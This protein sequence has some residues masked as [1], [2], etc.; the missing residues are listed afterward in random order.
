MLLK[1]PLLCDAASLPSSQPWSIMM[2][3]PPYV[4]TILYW[5]VF[6]DNFLQLFVNNQVK[7]YRW[8]IWEKISFVHVKIYLWIIWRK[9]S[10]VHVKKYLWI[11]WRNII[12]SCCC[13]SFL[14]AIFVSQQILRHMGHAKASCQ[15]FSL[16]IT[17][18][19]LLIMKIMVITMI[20]IEK[21][22]WLW[23]SW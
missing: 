17:E 2:Y 8:I 22:C 23:R 15:N 3:T 7:N 16:I 6:A 10:F 14:E 4:H 5:K 18:N 11:I 1:F 20:I 9:I 13:G 12:C 19:I 21:C